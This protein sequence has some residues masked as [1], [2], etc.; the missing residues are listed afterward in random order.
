MNQ[1]AHSLLRSLSLS[2]YVCVSVYDDDDD[3]AISVLRL[4]PI[5]YPR[6]CAI[7]V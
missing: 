2:L 3:E 7:Y 1:E 6:L 4:F 5:F